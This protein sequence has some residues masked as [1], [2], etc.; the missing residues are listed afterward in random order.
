M[1]CFRGAVLRLGTRH[2][3]SFCVARAA[4]SSP[5][6]W[7]VKRSFKRAEQLV[8][9]GKALA[10]VLN[11]GDVVLLT[12]TINPSLSLSPLPHAPLLAV[13]DR[14]AG[15][16]TL[17][18]GIIRVKCDDDDLPV[19]SPWFTSLPWAHHYH[20]AYGMDNEELLHH[21]DL[22]LLHRPNGIDL[23]ALDVPSIYDTS[24]CL[25]EMEETY[26]IEKRFFP[27]QHLEVRLSIDD[28]QHR[29]ME[30]TCVGEKWIKR[31]KDLKS[32]LKR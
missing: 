18:R 12:G 25:M 7:E 5:K 2:C 9:A 3:V 22:H 10:K 29:T 8:S 15:K 4:S 13:G 20:N 28:K 23:N 14:G 31:M 16:T 1:H 17:A 6:T 32:A 11:V 19:H 27:E 21:M 24:L 30:L 26:F